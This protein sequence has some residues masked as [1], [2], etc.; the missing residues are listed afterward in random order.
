MSEIEIASAHGHI[1]RFETILPMDE[2]SRAA[3]IFPGLAYTTNHPALKF[4]SLCCA[5]N[6]FTPILVNYAY[7][8]LFEVNQQE[9]IVQILMDDARQID[10]ALNSYLALSADILLLGKSLGLFLGCTLD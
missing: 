2:I 6:G 1:I 7:L 10:A 4:A 8:G 9:K 3:L 5:Q